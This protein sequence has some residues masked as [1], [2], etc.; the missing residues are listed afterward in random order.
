VRVLAVTTR[1]R[2]KSGPDTPAMAEFLPGFAANAWHGLFAP[3][4]TP[5]SII[6][7]LA[8]AMAAMVKD[9]AVSAQLEQA[10][11]IPVG[12]SPAA[13]KAFVDEETERWASV[14]QKLGLKAE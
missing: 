6:D 8:A 2:L 12:S 9:P 7:K 3:A 4:G 1:E 11:V 5:Q 13:F 10:D 14:V